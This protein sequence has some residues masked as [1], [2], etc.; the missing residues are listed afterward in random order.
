[1]AAPDP[2][3]SA[4]T[5]EERIQAVDARLAEDAFRRRAKRRVALRNAVPWRRFL[6]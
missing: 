6:R 1:M 4:K 3:S 5:C 2:T